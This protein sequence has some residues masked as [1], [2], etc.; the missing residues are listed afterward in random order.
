[1]PYGNTTPSME[2]QSWT[3][4]DCGAG[5]DATADTIDASERTA[6]T[7]DCD[8]GGVDLMEPPPAGTSAGYPARRYCDPPGP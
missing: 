4:T 2:T 5:L 1:M 3:P 8:L 6:L 7:S